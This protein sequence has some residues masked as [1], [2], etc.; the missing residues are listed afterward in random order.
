MATANFT[1][2]TSA[3][4]ETGYAF[5]A[6]QSEEDT[7]LIL[8]HLGEVIHT[9]DIKVNHNSRALV[10]SSRA[11]DFHTDHHKAKWVLWHC[12]EQ[13]D[14]GGESTLVDATL[15]YQ[16]L[17]D[18]NKEMLAQIMLFEH[19]VFD[20]DEDSYPLVKCTNG[21][22]EFYYSFWMADKDMPAV[23]KASLEAFR[24]AIENE[25]ATRLKLQKNDVLAIDNHRILHGRSAIEGHQNR[26]LKRFWIQPKNQRRKK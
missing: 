15:A 5:I 8:G 24:S 22:L 25:S 1:E 21:A 14:I 20:D 3:L 12:L 13:T 2:I 10:T 18:K 19:K 23:Q 11:L 16:K 7:A 17:E 4:T 6:N 9:T 26:F